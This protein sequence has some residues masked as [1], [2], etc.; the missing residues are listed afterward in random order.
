M[1]FMVVKSG[2]LINVNL[3]LS[4]VAMSFITLKPGPTSA[5]LTALAFKF[6]ALQLWM[7]QKY[8]VFIRVLCLQNL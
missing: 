4:N 8:A 2:I 1:I 5:L 7:E 6:L 3:V